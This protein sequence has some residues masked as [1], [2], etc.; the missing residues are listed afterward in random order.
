ML[1]NLVQLIQDVYEPLNKVKCIPVITT[2]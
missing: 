2:C 1:I